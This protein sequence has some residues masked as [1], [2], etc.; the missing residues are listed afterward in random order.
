MM[1]PL[2]GGVLLVLRGRDRAGAVAGSVAVAVKASAGLAVPFLVLGAR[3]RG[4]ALG[5]AVA[6]GAAV[7]VVALVAF[8]AHAFDFV[9]VLG[10][11][12]GLDSG[13]SVIAQLGAVF[14][15]TGNPTGAR[16]VATI[17]FAGTF[18]ALL[19][20]TWRRREEWL[21]S[22]AWA[23]VVLMACT[24]WL[25]AW[26]IVWLVPLAALGRSRWLQV[27]ATGLSLFVVLTRVVPF[28]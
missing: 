11:Q 27:A 26:Y 12:Q 10:S 20:R 24:S 6:T 14:G 15:W 21:D 16:A 25:L 23:T 17:V 5:A 22:A 8:G 3:E 4:R 7:L 19:R 2:L 9:N 18:L 1:L 13:T 28:L